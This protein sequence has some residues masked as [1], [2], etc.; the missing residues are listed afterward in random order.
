MEIFIAAYQSVDPILIQPAA[1][2]A[3]QTIAPDTGSTP[4]QQQVELLQKQQRWLA[5]QQAP[6]TK[7]QWRLAKERERLDSSSSSSRSS[8]GMV[9]PS[10]SQQGRTTSVWCFSDVSAATHVCTVQECELAVPTCSSSSRDCNRSDLR[11]R[12]AC[13]W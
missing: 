4:L 6:L 11:A 5:E 3:G 10:L 2:A 13:V 1:A 12:P 7:R 9:W 8:L